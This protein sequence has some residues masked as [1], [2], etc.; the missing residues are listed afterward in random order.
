MTT[1]NQWA[2]P[3]PDLVDTKSYR[4]KRINRAYLARTVVRGVKWALIAAG[5][6]TV[7]NHLCGKK[8]DTCDQE[9][10]V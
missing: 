3:N 8:D 6:V 5:T 2:P 1:N 7:A 9:E 10:T 4:M